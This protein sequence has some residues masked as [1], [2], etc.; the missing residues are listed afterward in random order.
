MKEFLAEHQED[1][2]EMKAVLAE[3]D[4]GVGLESDEDER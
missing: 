3:L 4:V 1:R 2:E